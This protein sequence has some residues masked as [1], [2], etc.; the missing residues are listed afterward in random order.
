MSAGVHLSPESVE[1]IAVRVAELLRE[2]PAPAAGPRLVDAATVAQRFG[3][4]RSWVYD[5]AAELG[6]VRLG[7]GPRG[8]L[9]FD[10]AK[11]ADALSV[12]S[13]R[14]GSETA[15]TRTTTRKARP[16]RRRPTGA[17]RELLP[18]RPPGSGRP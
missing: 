13:D 5:H 3:L 7:D 12:C 17:E 14:R 1:A 2:A 10:L 6:A 18:I 9:R 4:K 15:E 11:V 8:R 16:Q